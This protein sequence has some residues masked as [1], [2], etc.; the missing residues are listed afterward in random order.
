MQLLLLVQHM[1]VAVTVVVGIAAAIHL[2]VVA[3]AAEVPIVAVV[4]FLPV[5][6]AMT[7]DD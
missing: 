2:L 4:V 1:E 7:A 5:R 3:G 6:V